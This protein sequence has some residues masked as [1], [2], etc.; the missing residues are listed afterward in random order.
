MTVDEQIAQLEAENAKLRDEQIAQI[1]RQISFLQIRL[2]DLLERKVAEIEAVNRSLREMVASRRRRSPLKGRQVLE[3]Y[4]CA[5]STFIARHGGIKIPKDLKEEL[6]GW[7]RLHNDKG[8]AVDEMAEA[9]W[10]H[11]L[12]PE[13]RTNDLLDGLKS[14]RKSARAPSRKLYETYCEEEVKREATNDEIVPF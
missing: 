9:L 14:G 6:G 4:E 1:Q 10:E 8:L 12:I 5:V 13:P 11:G 7:W 2:D 3:D